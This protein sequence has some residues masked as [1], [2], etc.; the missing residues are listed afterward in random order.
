MEIEITEQ[1]EDSQKGLVPSIQYC[2]SVAEIGRDAGRITWDNAKHSEYRYITEDNKETVLDYFLSY[3]AWER[4]EIADTETL[5]AL[6]VQEIAHELRDFEDLADSNWMEF[7]KLSIEGVISA[8]IFSADNKT[9][10][11]IGS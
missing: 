2:G 4:E 9:Y 6:L 8:R 1:F 11:Y 5:N 7:E 10:I 3:G